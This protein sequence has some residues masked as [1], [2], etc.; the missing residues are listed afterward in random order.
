VDS[1]FAVNTLLVISNESRSYCSFLI[2]FI[3]GH[4]MPLLIVTFPLSNNSSTQN[5][6]YRLSKTFHI[7]N[8]CYERF[9]QLVNIAYFFIPE[10]G[11][12]TFH[13]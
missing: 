4:K 5:I 11:D 8:D 1:P 2:L 10:Q 12:L 13:D 6:L 3:D 9:K 7:P